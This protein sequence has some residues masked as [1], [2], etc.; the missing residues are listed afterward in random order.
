MYAAVYTTF[1]TQPHL[2][3]R[4]RLRILRARPPSVGRSQ[5]LCGLKSA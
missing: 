5:R 3:S 4:P 2:I 1:D